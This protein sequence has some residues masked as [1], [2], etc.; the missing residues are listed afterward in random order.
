MDDGSRPDG[1]TE[2]EGKLVPALPLVPGADLYSDVAF[3]YSNVLLNYPGS[4]LVELASQA[5]LDSK[6]FVKK[7]PFKDKDQL[8]RFICQVVPDFYE[9]EGEP[10]RGSPPGEIVVLPLHATLVELKQEAKRALSETYCVM[11]EF[12]VTD[13]E[14]MDKLGDEDLLFGAIESGS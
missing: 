8:L 13:I 6:H 1:I 5:I 3:L 12:V 11:E 7:W 14:H 9:L 4:G 10:Y 2:T